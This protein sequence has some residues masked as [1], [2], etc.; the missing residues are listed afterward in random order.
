[1]SHLSQEKMDNLFNKLRNNP[2]LAEHLGLTEDDFPLEVGN[3]RKAWSPLKVKKFKKGSDGKI[4]S[5]EKPV[6]DSNRREDA[7]LESSGGGSSRSSLPGT[8]G[9]TQTAEDECSGPE[10]EDEMDCLEDILCSEGQDADCANGSDSDDCEPFEVLCAP[11]SASWSPSKKTLEFYLKAADIPLT[12]EVLNGIGE[13]Y[14]ADEK[15]EVHFAPP[16]FPASLWSSVQSSPSDT[17][18]LKNLFRVQENLYLA[19]KPLL[20]VLATADEVA[21][22][23]I[24]Q[25]IQLICSSNLDLN[26]YRRATIAP[27]IKTDLR[28]QML[29]LPVSHNSLFGEDFSKTTDNLIKENSTIEKI[30]QKKPMFQRVSFNQ[31]SNHG[32]KQFFRGQR[33][34]NNF[35][36]NRGSFKRNNFYRRGQKPSQSG[37]NSN[38]TAKPSNSTNS[39]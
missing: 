38:Q 29:A 14:R 19:I 6:E 8:S 4:S 22:P 12:K 35:Q 9:S 5:N 26:R 21:K 39:Q 2:K 10:G 27:H 1:M 13:K 16:R 17:Y 37:S 31:S 15:L 36:K 11:N 25:S 32:Q 28:K 18:R 30:L 24:I 7:V 23:K 34:R 33:T 3:K 20:D